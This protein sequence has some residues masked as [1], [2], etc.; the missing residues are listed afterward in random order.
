M[1]TDMHTIHS[2]TFT[3][4]LITRVFQYWMRP[5]LNWLQNLTHKRT[6]DTSEKTKVGR[7]R[8]QKVHKK[9]QVFFFHVISGESCNRHCLKNDGKPDS[10]PP[11]FGPT[12]RYASFS[13]NPRQKWSLN[14]DLQAIHLLIQKQLFSGGW[15]IFSLGNQE[16]STVG[17]RWKI[18]KSTRKN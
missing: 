8:M 5:P 4:T 3:S 13:H 15:N 17:A 2:N 14:C 11:T 12:S 7:I 6:Y 1:G 18:T 10:P 9:E 16:F